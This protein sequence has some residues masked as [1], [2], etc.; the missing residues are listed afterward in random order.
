[1]VRINTIGYLPT[2]QTNSI[3]GLADDVGDHSD[4][5]EIEEEP[6]EAPL[7]IDNKPFIVKKFRDALR[8]KD[9]I[10]GTFQHSHKC[11]PELFQ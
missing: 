6:K 9:C 2:Y 11:R 10:T 7:P 8:S 5:N 1:M 4:A 3:I